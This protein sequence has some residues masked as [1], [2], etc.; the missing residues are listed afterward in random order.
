MLILALLLAGM[1]G[2]AAFGYFPVQ[3]W[4]ARRRRYAKG[5]LSRAESYIRRNGADA[6]SVVEARLSE[7]DI[8][9]NERRFL[10]DVLKEIR[11]GR[12]VP[13]PGRFVFRQGLADPDV[14]RFEGG[15]CAPRSRRRPTSIGATAAQ[16]PAMSHSKSSAADS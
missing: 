13:Q 5:V 12:I 14:S 16:T 15:A 11:R 8:S 1:I 4:R 3:E 9:V 7:P 2:A 10:S 6:A